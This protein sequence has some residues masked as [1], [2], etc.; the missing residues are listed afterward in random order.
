MKANRLHVGVVLAELSNDFVDEELM[1]KAKERSSG[2]E[3][4]ALAHYLILR[5]EFHSNN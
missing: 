5:S 3:S 2:I 4:T 1:R